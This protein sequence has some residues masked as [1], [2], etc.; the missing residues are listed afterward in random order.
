MPRAGKGPWGDGPTGGQVPWLLGMG[1]G[2]MWENLGRP[3][4]VGGG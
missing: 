1:L 3:G 4:W 2:R